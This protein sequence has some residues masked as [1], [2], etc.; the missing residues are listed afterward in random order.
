MCYMVT[1]YVQNGS[2]GVYVK[3]SRKDL[4]IIDALMSV[5]AWMY[6]KLTE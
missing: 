2:V 6:G 3:A 1:Y 4:S 5:E